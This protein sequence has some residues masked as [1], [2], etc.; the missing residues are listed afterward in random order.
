MAKNLPAVPEYL[1]APKEE[2]DKARRM[3]AA[4]LQLPKNERTDKRI[5]EM[6]GVS[7]LTV[8]RYRRAFHW[9]VDAVKRDAAITDPFIDKHQ[10]EI[11]AG[12]EEM[13]HLTKELIRREF[14]RLGLKW[15]GEKVL[16]L[17]EEGLTET[18]SAEAK[19]VLKVA[20]DYKELLNLFELWVKTIHGRNPNQAKQDGPV[21]KVSIDKAV[22]EIHYD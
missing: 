10:N 16:R 18:A 4:Y 12:F 19:K 1:K 14:E 22:I 13:F 3:R 11:N 15:D 5:A 20:K 21:P 6:F 2:N 17:A 7:E 8:M 9:E